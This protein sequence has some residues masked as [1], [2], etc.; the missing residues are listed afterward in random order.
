M[1]KEEEKEFIIRIK[2]RIKQKEDI[3]KEYERS[4]RKTRQHKKLNPKIDIKKS[5]LILNDEIIKLERVISELF[6]VINIYKDVLK[7]GNK[8]W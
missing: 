7:G 3:I 2:N 1:N 6:N 4:L 8:K 5:E